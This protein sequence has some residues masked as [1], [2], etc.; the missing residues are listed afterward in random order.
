M[1]EKIELVYNSL[2]RIDIKPTPVNTSILN[3]VYAVLR[4]IYKE[5]E[6]IENAKPENGTT[7]DLQ[8]RDN[9]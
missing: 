2:Q 1:K 3:D 4:G 8:G 9:D 6:E 7:A 5:L